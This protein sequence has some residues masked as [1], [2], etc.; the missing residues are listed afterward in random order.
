[1]GRREVWTLERAPSGTVE[2]ILLGSEKGFDISFKISFR[3]GL[4]I[5]GFIW[6]VSR[7]SEIWEVEFAASFMS[8]LL[9]F[10][11]SQPLWYEYTRYSITTNRMMP[12]LRT[13][14]A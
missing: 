14:T 1:L 11:K 10:N 5:D 6:H 13:T 9:R 12:P 8:P 2:G 4:S 3:I 7:Y